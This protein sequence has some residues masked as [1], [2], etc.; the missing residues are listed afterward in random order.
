MKRI[1]ILVGLAIAFATLRD[2]RAQDAGVTHVVTYIEVVPGTKD[3]GATLVRQYREATRKED[4]N[5]RA[6]AVR[7]IAQPNQFVVIES[8]KDRAAFDAHA[9]SASTTHLRE[10][11]KSIQAAPP[12]ER[13]HSGLSVGPIG[14]GRIGLG[15]V[16]AVTHIDVI[17]PRKDDGTAAV[18][19][20]AVDSRKSGGNLRA[21][22][23]VQANRPNHF[24]SVEI[25]RNRSAADAHASSPRVRA[26]RDA[27]APM[28]GAL[29]DER[30]YK[31]M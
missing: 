4:G 21:D 29:Y 24:T 19:Q 7:R 18:R 8:W 13:V 28:S 26:F 27:I 1:C 22:M 12:D 31:P 20:H 10:R 6:E 2:A 3:T 16:Y 25:W 23:L 17:P 14:G 15:A 9:K 5:L 30:F 11:L